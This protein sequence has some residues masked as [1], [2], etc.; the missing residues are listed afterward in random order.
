MVGNVVVVDAVHFNVI[1][2]V[3]VVEAVMVDAVA[4]VE[5]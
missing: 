5:L 1:V 3:E 4:V 2:T